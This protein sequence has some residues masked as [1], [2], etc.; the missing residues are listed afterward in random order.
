MTTSLRN[1]RDNPVITTVDSFSVPLDT[2]EFPSVTVCPEPGSVKDNFNYIE[3]LLNLID[4]AQTPKTSPAGD[5]LEK[6]WDPASYK[7][8]CFT[9]ETKFNKY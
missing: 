2:I 6:E 8:F 1:W 9:H 4:V 5:K 7:K 3:K